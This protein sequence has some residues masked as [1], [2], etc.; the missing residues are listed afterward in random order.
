MVFKELREKIDRKVVHA[1]IALSAAC[2][3]FI[4]AVK[5]KAADLGFLK[6]GTDNG[7]FSEITSAAKQTGFS[8]YNL[9]LVVGIIGVV[10]SLVVLGISFAFSKN[11]N[12]KS[13]NKSHLVDICIGALFI[14]GALT[15]I[16]LIKTIAD[17]VG[18]TSAE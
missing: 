16:G 3:P 18:T 14:F 1:G 5:A 9:L 4:D 12:K 6:E 7:A 13:E 17:K 15:F 11:A 2:T 10:C 8:F